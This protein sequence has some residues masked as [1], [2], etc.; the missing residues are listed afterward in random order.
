MIRM[1]ADET[2]REEI[3]ALNDQLVA[4]RRHFHQ[5]P[6]LGFEERETSDYVADRLRSL[7]IETQTGIAETGV[8]GLIRGRGPGKTVLLRADMDALPLTEETG[9][10]YASRRPGV[11]HA[12]GHDGHTAILLAVAELLMR[13]RDSF[14]GAVKLVFQ[15]A[16]EGPG[17]AEPMIA[18]GVMEH[19]HVDACFGLH[20]ANA[21]PVGTLMARGGPVQASADDF[22][23][24]VRGVGGHGSSPHETVDAI[25]VG[26][27]IVMALHRIVSREVDP[28]D[29]AVVTVGAFHG[30]SRHNIIAASATLVGTLR[31]LTPETREFL[32]QRVREVASG[33]AEASRARAEVTIN[34][35]YPVTV[36][37]EG[38]AAF[39]RE[40]AQTIVA[41]ENVIEGRPIMGSEDMSYFL[42]AAPGCFVFVGSRNEERDLRHP[43]HSPLFDFDEAALPI[44]VELL[45]TLALEYLQRP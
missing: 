31:A 7:G 17:G 42:N 5:Y 28:L 32:H 43:H 2:V 23:I 15:P 3:R 41:P 20:L 6:E 18:A 13:R 37:D 39:A 12:C 34:L 8:V 26:A 10:P 21:L 40:V 22:E 9:A 45:T 33:I 1:P 14:D 36:N 24:T 29:Q 16:E 19:P 4:D 11:H 30:G 25:A 38:M 35:G 27:A 44:G